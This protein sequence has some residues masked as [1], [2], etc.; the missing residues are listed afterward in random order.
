MLRRA[1]QIASLVAFAV[2]LGA[3]IVTNSD[4]TAFEWVLGADPSLSL[5]S[6]ISGRVF[7]AAFIPAVVLMALGFVVGRG[8]CGYVCPMGTCVDGIDH[9]IAAKRS[10]GNRWRNA[11]Y[12]ILGLMLG[13]A[14]LG[15]SLVYLASP[16]SLIAR[17]LG[18]VV[19]PVLSA[20]TEAGLWAVRPVAELADWN[21]VVFAKVETPSFDTQLFLLVFLGGLVAA[22]RVAPRFWCANLC[23]A[24]AMLALTSWRP[25]VRRRVS[26]ACGGC[27]K[28]ADVC[29]MGA[30]DPDDQFVTRHDECILCRT[31]QSVCP[32]GAVSFLPS[33]EEVAPPESAGII[34]GRRQFVLGGLAGLGTAGTTLV[35]AEEHRLRPPGAVPEADFLARCVRCAACV[36]VCPQNALQPLYDATGMSGLFSPGLV[37]AGGYCDPECSRCGAVCP[38]EAIVELTGEERLWAKT[39]T[40]E[41]VR[42]DCLAWENKEKCMVCD[43]VCPFDAVVFK[44]E[45]DHPVTVPHVEENKCVGCG[46]CENACPVKRP[47]AI[48]VAPKNAVRLMAGSYVAEGRKRG[49]DIAL[50]ATPPLPGQNG[51][52][53][54]NDKSDTGPAPGF[55]APAPGF[56]P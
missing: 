48:R 2:L 28:C 31:C 26:Q 40:A 20:L 47:A 9:V 34:V 36:A 21:A 11:K 46:Y 44:I 8:F 45:P 17:I 29:P 1:V 43:E 23:P 50:D 53:T 3:A 27:A 25:V 49:L 15:V 33:P 18:I 16:F 42:E 6:A 14:A 32:K 52:E 30:I 56:S 7:M 12:V 19:Y 51:V 54:T 5:M 38:T 13:A 22:A 37:P 41:I 4:T 55:D 10:T 35:K 24:G 39:G